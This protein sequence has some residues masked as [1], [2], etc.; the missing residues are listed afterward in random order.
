MWHDTQVPMLRWAAWAWPCGMPGGPDQS[1]GWNCSAP[2]TPNS[3]SSRWPK[4]TRSWQPWQ[5]VC[6]RWQLWQSE[7]AARADLFGM[8]GEG[9]QRIGGDLDTRTHVVYDRLA[10]DG[11]LYAVGYRDDLVAA[12]RG[13][14]VALQAGGNLRIAH[15]VYFTVV[16]EQLF[17]RFYRS[18]FRALGMLSF[19]WAVR[20][21][22][23]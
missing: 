3:P 7:V 12:R 22:R 1:L 16:G 11:R 2:P 19:D 10:I 14:S 21:G 5:N 20:G 4:P 9:G 18:A 13:Y 6:A 8:G 23:R 17:T 15:G